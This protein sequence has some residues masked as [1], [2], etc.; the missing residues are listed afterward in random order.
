MKT[1]TLRP[2]RDK[3]VL[4]GHPWI[5]SG[6]VDRVD[7]APESGETVAVRSASGDFLAWAAFSPLSNIRARVW[8]RSQDESVDAAF[9]HRRL[10][11]ALNM[12]VAMNIRQ[13]TNAMRLVHGESDG[14]PGLV[15]DQYNRW[16]V[17]QFLSAGPER[18]RED[19]IR[20]LVELFQPEGIFERSDVDVRELEGLLPR[21]GPLAGR[22][23]VG[24]VE[25]LE[26]EIR[27]Q[28]NLVEGQ[29][30]GFYV[31][32]RFN[33]SRLRA[34]AEGREALNCFCY[35]GGFSLSALAGGARSVLSID[36]SVDALRQAQENARLNGMT[37]PET[38]WL[39][40]DVFTALRKLRD[41][42]RSFDLIVLDPPKFAPTA[43]QAE[44]AARGYKDINLLAFKLL[45]PG[46]LLFTF[47]CSGGVSM[48]L[49][50]KIVA[51]A[52]QDANA[53]ALVLERL[54]QGRDHP[55]SLN[56]PEGTYLKGLV[57][58]KQA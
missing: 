34:Y 11:T 24:P 53:D 33:R 4:Q 44:R 21:T 8:T 10:A 2:G 42:A 39:E 47:S 52:A 31:D 32:Q 41:Q 6:A 54:Y 27:Y 20:Q 49:F 1:L 13:E 15:V 45:R 57:C 16:L 29:K 48:D 26:N 17:V 14:L 30:T 51:G 58:V 40:A 18:W 46:G 3:S 56:F 28:V 22:A 37:V 5:F 36:S 7:G 12:R 55:V 9:F 38:D 43:A 35:T 23:P 50:Q 25:I 19:I